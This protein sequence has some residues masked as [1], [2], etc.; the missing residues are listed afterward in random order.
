MKTIKKNF[1]NYKHYVNKVDFIDTEYTQITKNAH[2][3][4]IKIN[5]GEK[6]F[7]T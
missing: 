3:S 2:K 6:V 1:L 5:F 4:R 7:D